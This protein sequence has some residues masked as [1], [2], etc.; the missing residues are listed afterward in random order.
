MRQFTKPAVALFVA[1]TVCGL[2]AQSA[3]AQFSS[4]SRT[5]STSGNALT[6]TSSMGGMGVS[7]GF[8]TNSSGLGGTS[9]VGNSAFGNNAANRTAGNGQSALGQSLFNQGTTQN[10][11]IGGRNS[12]QQFIGG[13]QRTGQ[14]NNRQQT[15]QFGNQSRQNRSNQDDM[16]DPNG[17]QSRSNTN[18]R[19]AVR[20]QQK[21]AFEIPQ[22]TETEIRT[23]LQTQ[24]TALSQHPTLSGVDCTMDS[25]GV[26]ILSGTVASA[27]ARLLAANVVRLEP[28]VRRVKNE[29]TP[30]VAGK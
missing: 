14:Q 16:N 26:V 11:F 3:A 1:A 7:S 13:N 10:G 5:G 22:R 29:L 17:N 4:S 12:Q 18:Q 9:G 6:S 28:G 23:T 30:T 8:G 2:F 21:V 25:D 24:F 19:R 20:P 15:N 27:S